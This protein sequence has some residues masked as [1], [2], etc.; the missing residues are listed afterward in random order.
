MKKIKLDKTR[1]LFIGSC[2]EGRSERVVL[3]GD[4]DFAS[5][6]YEGK[7]D[8]FVKDDKDVQRNICFL[9]FM[10]NNSTPSIEDGMTEDEIIEVFRDRLQLYIKS[11]EAFGQVEK[12]ED[13]RFFKIYF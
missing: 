10:I 11:R 8:I 5:N 6:L 13:G 7:E 12:D 9:D 3:R 4:V 1:T 2:E